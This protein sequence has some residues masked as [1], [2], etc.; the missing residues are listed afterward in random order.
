MKP[1]K[2]GP[3][4]HLTADFWDIRKRSNSSWQCKA[5]HRERQWTSPII[6]ER[7]TSLMWV[8]GFAFPELYPVLLG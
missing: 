5:S 7:P 2:Y 8:S 1:S 4:R 3:C 6:M